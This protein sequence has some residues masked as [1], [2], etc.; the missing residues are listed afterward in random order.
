MISIR[1][2]VHLLLVIFTLFS[3]SVLANAVH[4]K[5]LVPEN[6]HLSNSDQLHPAQCSDVEHHADSDTQQRCASS[7]VL[8][9]PLSQAGS[10][11]GHIDSSLAPMAQDCIG[12]AITRIQTLF[13]PPIA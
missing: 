4:A 7:C 11:V 13:R 5:T 6:I 1:T 3:T 12:E 10:I 9:A 8:K 2:F